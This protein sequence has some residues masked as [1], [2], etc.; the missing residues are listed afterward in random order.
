MNIT[1]LSAGFAK[2]R[3]GYWSSLS[4][5]SATLLFNPSVAQEKTAHE[6]QAVEKVELDKYLGVWYEIARKPNRFEEKCAADVTASYTLNEYGNMLIENQCMD[7][8]GRKIQAFGEA[9]A[10][11]EP[12]YSQFK[13]SF[14]PEGMRW[15]PVGQS[16]YWVLKV[17]ADY[18]MALVGEPNRQ[19]LWLLSRDKKPDPAQV[20][21]Y[22]AYAETLGYRLN[23]VV[24]VE[25][26]R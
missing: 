6:L 10:V 15:L 3:F 7:Q 13:V 19:Y 9:Y 8:N 5:L 21:Q 2:Y 14:L 25:Q 12:R 1:F 17:D 26:R 4:L 24:Y 18:Q 20:K 11:N 22:L 23:D 16:D